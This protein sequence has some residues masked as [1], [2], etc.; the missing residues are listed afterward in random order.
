MSDKNKL[1]GGFTLLEVIL[2]IAVVSL[3][4][5]FILEMFVVSNRVNK[6]AFEI[7][8]AN[9]ICM[10]AVESF[11]NGRLSD[12]KSYDKYFDSQWKSV[13]L[14]THAEYTLKVTVYPGET[15]IYNVNAIMLRSN[16]EEIASID[17]TKYF[18]DFS[19]GGGGR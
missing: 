13:N 7:D 8:N 17:A 11:K 5:V 14:I 1:N 9:I 19:A 6:K 10:E 18:A 15:D 2:S 3:I 4:S 16:G 12:G